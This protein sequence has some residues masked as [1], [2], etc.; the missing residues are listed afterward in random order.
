MLIKSLADWKVW[1]GPRRF[2]FHAPDRRAADEMLNNAREISQ[3]LERWGMHDALIFWPDCKKRYR[4]PA[5]IQSFGNYRSNKI[6]TEI[7]RIIVPGVRIDSL[8]LSRS[9]LDVFGYFL[10]NPELKGALVRRADNRQIA[11]SEASQG[12]C[13]IP[14]EEAVKRRREDYWHLPDLDQ[15]MRESRR[16]LEP[17][18]PDSTLEFSWRS[19]GY[20]SNWRQFTNRYRLIRDGFGNLYEVSENLGVDACQP[21]A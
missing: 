3:S 8:R 14:L 16:Q 19:N 17:D 5:S 6:M 7:E 20:G 18:N 15:F 12:I 11:M 13:S 10:E 21:A 9:L 4:I 2:I 1:I